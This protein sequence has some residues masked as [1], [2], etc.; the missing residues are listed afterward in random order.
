MLRMSWR[1]RSIVDVVVDGGEHGRPW[2]VLGAHVRRSRAASGADDVNFVQAVANV[3]AGAIERRR[4]EDAIRHRALHDDLTG[5]PNRALFLDRL[6]HA[7]A[8]TGPARQQRRR[9][10]HRHRPVQGRERLARPPVGRPAAAVGRR[11]GSPARCGPATRWRASPATSSSSCARASRASRRAMAVAERLLELLRRAVRAGRPRA[12]R[13]RQHRRSRCRAR[14]GQS[15]EELIR[16]ADTAMYRAKERGR[17]ALRAVRRPHARAHAR[18]HADRPRPAPRRPGRGPA[19]ALP[20]DRRRWPTATSRASR[21]CCAGSHPGRGDVPPAEFIPIAEES[22]LIGADRALGARAG[23]RAGR[24]LARPG[25]RG[26]GAAQRQRQSLGAPVRP[27]PAGRRGGR[28]AR[29]HRPRARPADARDHRVGA[30]G[31]GRRGGRA[32]CTR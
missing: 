19:R 12:V 13:L 3:L 20:A 15:A 6:E 26:R 16:D 4:A 9:D 7:L 21:R 25:G 10:L 18:A 31:R 5:L 8:Q 22:G 32:S 23:G 28:G 17:A 14:D 29:G 11:R 27:G 24:A 2:G 1:S 30:D